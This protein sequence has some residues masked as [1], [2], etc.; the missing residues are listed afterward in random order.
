[1]A[2]TGALKYAA[3][4]DDEHKGSLQVDDGNKKGHLI[5]KNVA[6]LEKIYDLQECFQGTKN[7]KTHSS[8]MMHELI[9]LR[10]EQDSKFV[11]LGTCFTQQEWQAFVHLFKQ[12]RDVFAW[13]Y[14]D[15]K[16][17]DTQII[18]HIIPIKE[19]V[20]PYQKKPRKV[21]PLLEPLIQ[22]ELT[23]LL[24]A[25]IIYK[26]R[27]STWVSNL[28][29]IHKK[30]GEI[31]FFVDFWNVNHTLDKDNYPVPPMDHIL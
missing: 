18:Q 28:V 26:V 27:Y 10:I 23:K 2:N 17:Y 21:H 4:D 12:Y 3:I 22:K 15:L 14:D 13:T 20:K 30:F 16:T 29:P 31:H 7:S 1:M 5:M 8:T 9:N 19:W 6:T 11:N 24:D 25:R